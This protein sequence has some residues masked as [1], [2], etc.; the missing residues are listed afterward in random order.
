MSMGRQDQMMNKL[1]RAIK[2]PKATSTAMIAKR[3]LRLAKLNRKAQEL[4]YRD[5]QATATAI[6]N[7]GL[8]QPINV[9][10]QGDGVT[11]RDGNSLFIK[12]FYMKY[13][14]Q[15]DVASSTAS[16]TVRVIL[17]QDKQCDQASPSFGDVLEDVTSLDILTSAIDFNNSRRFKI[18]YDRNHSLNQ[19]RTNVTVKKFFKINQTTKFLNTGATIADISTNAYFLMFISDS[20]SE[21]PIL[22]S[23]LRMRFTD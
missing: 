11:N 16:Q 1:A 4:K 13:F 20:V 19:V 12:S 7:T 3:A 9:A 15:W 2:R 23:F 14:L 21:S 5:V 22:T 17:V 10:A 18:L 6:D 8:V